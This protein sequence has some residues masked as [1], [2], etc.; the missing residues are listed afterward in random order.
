MTREFIFS[1]QQCSGERDAR[2]VVKRTLKNRENLE[3][4]KHTH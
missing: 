3:A 2:S 4:G 1:K